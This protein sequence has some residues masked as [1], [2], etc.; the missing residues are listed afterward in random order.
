MFGKDSSDGRV[1]SVGGDDALLQGR[2]TSDLA[3]A[4]WLPVCVGVDNLRRT[5][6]SEKAKLVG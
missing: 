2:V 6:H 5:A 1:P 3:P 4:R